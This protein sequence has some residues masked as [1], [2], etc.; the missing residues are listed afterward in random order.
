MESINFSPQACQIKHT[1]HISILGVSKNECYD[2]FP[3]CLKDP[4]SSF[5]FK[6]NNIDSEVP[7]PLCRFVWEKPLKTLYRNKLVTYF[8]NNA[9]FN[10]LIYI[11]NGNKKCKCHYKHKR[12]CY[13]SQRTPC[14]ERLVL[15]Q[16]G[17]PEPTLITSEGLI[18]QGQMLRCYQVRP[19][20]KQAD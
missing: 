18:S 6:R 20:I 14:A 4:S 3:S 11:G 9:L 15:L 16:F 13:C 17:E 19:Q 5:W 12:Q 10:E 7:S 8:A 2:I 1:E